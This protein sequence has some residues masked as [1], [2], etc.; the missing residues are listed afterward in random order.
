MRPEGSYKE[1]ILS[2]STSLF[3]TVCF[4]AA[5]QTA[6]A[7]FLVTKTDEINVEL[8]DFY[9]EDSPAVTAETIAGFT[10]FSKGS[11][12]VFTKSRGLGDCGTQASYTLENSRFVLEKMQEKECEELDTKASEINIDPTTWP[13]TYQRSAVK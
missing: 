2:E 9:R 13:V 5:Y 8:V 3:E 7:Y 10:D 4:Q 6:Y 11:L 12:K 1:Y